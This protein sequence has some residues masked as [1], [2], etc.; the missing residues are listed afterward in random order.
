MKIKPQ[1]RERDVF[2][3]K[4]LQKEF[5]HGRELQQAVLTEPDPHTVVTLRRAMSTW[6]RSLPL[7]RVASPTWMGPT[8][9]PVFPCPRPFPPLQPGEGVRAL[10]WIACRG[11]RHKTQTH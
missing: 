8:S 9:D 6:A 4:L 3:F 1:K 10:R 11:R 5:S 2:F 7:V